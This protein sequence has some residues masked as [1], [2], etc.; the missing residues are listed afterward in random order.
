MK[1]N[2]KKLMCL[3]FVIIMLFFTMASFPVSAQITTED[4]DGDGL[5]DAE[6]NTTGT[7]PKDPDT[8][9]DGIIDSEDGDPLHKGRVDVYHGEEK[10]RKEAQE[11]LLNT[12]LFVLLLSFAVFSLIAGIFTAYFGAGK[13]RAIGG[14]LL[15]LGLV[16]ILI[17]I[18]FGVLQ[19]YPDDTILNIV[20]WEAAKTLEA[21]VTVIGAVIGAVIAIILFLVAIMKS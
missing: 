1:L 11:S 21:F 10:D 4:S 15:V 17:W 18:Y 19:D 13:S 2:V 3:F 16:V 14:I 6:E 8:D 20:H 9:G 5:K 7:D 12:F